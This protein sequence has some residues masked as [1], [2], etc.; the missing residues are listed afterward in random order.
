MEKLEKLLNESVETDDAFVS[1]SKQGKK[2]HVT[3]KGRTS[4]ILIALASLESEVLEDAHVSEETFSK[5]KD[6]VDR[7]VLL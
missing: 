2:L 1:I 7:A 3:A 6:F 5:I 4:A